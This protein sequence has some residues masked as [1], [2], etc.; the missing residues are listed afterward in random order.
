VLCL[1]EQVAGVREIKG[2][3]P[4][5]SWE[6]LFVHSLGECSGH[7]SQAELRRQVCH[8]HGFGDQAPIPDCN[9]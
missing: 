7:S 8:Q 2:S 1:L 6:D 9:W 5:G 4:V 3:Y